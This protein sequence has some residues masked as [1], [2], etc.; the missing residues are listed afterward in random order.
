MTPTRR[1]GLLCVRRHTRTHT[2]SRPAGAAKT[3]GR[4]SCYGS[5]G[6]SPSASGIMQPG[7]CQQPVS[8]K[9]TKG[10]VW[11]RKQKEVVQ[12]PV[13]KCDG[14]SSWV[15]TLCW[16]HCPDS[17]LGSATRSWEPDS[18]VHGRDPSGPP[19]YFRAGFRAGAQ[20]GRGAERGTEQTH[21]RPVNK[22]DDIH[23]TIWTSQISAVS[24]TLVPG[25]LER[26]VN[27]HLLGV[28]INSENNF[29]G[30]PRGTQQEPKES[31]ML[32]VTGSAGHLGGSALRCSGEGLDAAWGLDQSQRL[33]GYCRRYR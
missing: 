23:L 24:S 28:A 13:R 18:P 5:C 6:A 32:L 29:K 11:L 25:G 9:V 12:C 33:Y 16:K 14:S 22:M 31:A 10:C 2:E 21:I 15:W 8:A 30:I 3:S 1:G 19:L 7:A 27:S 26:G 20:W 4:S 17:G